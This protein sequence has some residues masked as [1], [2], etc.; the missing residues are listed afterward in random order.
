MPE[1]G[2]LVFSAHAA[3]FCSRSGGTLAL[4]RRRGSA[5]HVVD[6]TFGERGESE[7]YWAQPGPKSIEEAKR[8]R[9]AEAEE[10]AGTLGVTIEFLDYGD[11]PLILGA[12]RLEAMAHLIRRRKPDIILTHWKCDPFNADHEVTAGG[13]LRAAAMAAVPGFDHQAGKVA[14]PYIFAFEP[15]IPRDDT[16]GFCPDHYVKITRCSTSKWPRS[17]PCARNRSWYVFTRSGRSIAGSR[18][19]SRRAGSSAAR[20]LSS[21]TPPW[22]TCGCRARTR[23]PE[24]GQ[25]ERV[26]CRGMASRDGSRAATVA[27]PSQT[28]RKVPPGG[29]HFIRS[30]GT[31]D[32]TPP[33]GTSIRAAQTRPFNSRR[34]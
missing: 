20:K 26:R 18:R 17:A 12:E 10:A 14:Y 31:V 29:V 27:V 1:P 11:Y 7:D 32:T 6:V 34:R 22:W 21:A 16:T 4:H 13:V 30:S 25:R 33:A 19:R 9:A 8:V 5:V 3:D 24:A 23:S 28:W 15:T 2:I